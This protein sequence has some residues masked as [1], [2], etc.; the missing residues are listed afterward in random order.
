LVREGSGISQPPSS[1]PF[2]EDPQ[3]LYGIDVKG[4]APGAAATIDDA[5]TSFPFKLSALPPGRYRVQAVLD[6]HRDNSEWKREPGNL[7]S[8]TQTIEVSAQG[9]SAPTLI[10]LAHEVKPRQPRSV[11]GVEIVQVHSTLLTDFHHRDMVL[12]AGVVLPIGYDAAASRQYPAVYEVPGFGGDADGAYPHAAR[13]RQWIADSPEGRLARDAFWIVLDPESGNG[14]TLFADSANNGP[15]GEALVKELIPALEARYHLFP[16]ASARLLRGHSSGGWSTLWLALTY[17][18]TFGAAWS[19]SPDPVDFHSFQ[20]PDIYETPNMYFRWRT[21]KPQPDGATLTPGPD[22][23]SYRVSGEPK[24]TIRQENLMEEVLGPENTSGQQWDSWQAVFGPRNDLGSP[25]ALY[26]PRTG[27]IDQDVAE[28]YRKYDISALLRAD[29]KKY[30]PIF[31]DSVRVVVGDQDSFYLNE[32]VALLKQHVDE[33]QAKSNRAPG[34]GS[35]TI[36]PSYDHGS[37]F[38]APELRS[39]PQQMLD[40]LQHDGLIPSPSK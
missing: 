7:Y 3:P 21:G 17:P 13:S 33:Q 35:I 27:A 12:R 23:P 5:A 38:A 26:D 30:L 24:M 36:L 39:I 4:L 1:G 6:L 29:P 16:H 15:C 34:W 2:W 32:A 20:L 8:D 40:R 14:H 25:A 28:Q 19:T 22:F 31:R 11:P 37:I 18:D 9:P 10:P